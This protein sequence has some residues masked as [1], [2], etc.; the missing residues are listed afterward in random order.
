VF[1]V[2]DTLGII[3]GSGII[4]RTVDSG[5]TWQTQD[6][7]SS[8]DLR[9]V[10]FTDVSTA[11]AV[12]WR[13]TIIRSN[14]GGVNW[15]LIPNE[16]TRTL[17]KAFF[18]DALVGYA[19][20]FLG[21]VLRTNDGGLTWSLQNSGTSH[22]L[23]DVYFFDN[24]IGL[25]VGSNGTILRTETGGVVSVRDSHP[26]P[27]HRFSEPF[28]L[29]PNH[30]NPFNASTAISFLLLEPSQVMLK[31]FNVKGEEVA[32]IVKAS[33]SAGQHI[34]FWQTTDVASGIY[35]YRLSVWPAGKQM[36]VH[37]THKM[38]LLR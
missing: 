17:N 1:F 3:V 9:S 8:F 6:V 14:D 32:E 13:G 18:V 37:E 15:Q 31:I 12:G 26:S 21:T 22:V 33:L 28:I 4:L 10:F 29:Y 19:V 11:I 27:P 34:Y 30:P 25:A 36:P 24:N 35:F 16:V 7:D 38:L 20:G 2:N 5:E 23:E